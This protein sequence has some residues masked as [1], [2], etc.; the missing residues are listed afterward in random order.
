MRRELAYVLSLCSTAVNLAACGSGTDEHL[1]PG[2]FIGYADQS[3]VTDGYLEDQASVEG[4]P[5]ASVR[6]SS[7]TV[8]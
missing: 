1:A 3:P 5:R 4:A 7:I 8:R 6:P 2:T